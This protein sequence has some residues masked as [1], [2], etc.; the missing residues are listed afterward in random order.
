[1][2]NLP[3]I[4]ASSSPARLELLQRIKIF[5]DKILPPDIDESERKGE[6]PGK[7][8]L[9]LAFEKATKIAQDVEEGV[10]IAADTVSVAGRKTLP[11]AMNKDDIKY[12]LEHVSGRRHR[13]YTGVCII[14]TTAHETV[15]RKRVVCSTLKLKRLTDKEIEFYCSL[16]EGL[17]K[18]G[19]YTITGYAECFVSYIAGSYSNVKGL[20]LFETVNMLNSLGVYPAADN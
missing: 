19:G 11:K 5:P 17:N 4:L 13:V 7:L 2:N 15:V 9:R 1:M 14:K 8:A 3:I 6:L 12:C 20:P 18:A 10:I 16:D